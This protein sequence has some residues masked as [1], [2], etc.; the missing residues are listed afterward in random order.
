MRTLS[1]YSDYYE[2]KEF[3]LLRRIITR[4]EYE[5]EEYDLLCLFEGDPDYIIEEGETTF[6]DWYKEDETLIHTNEEEVS[7]IEDYLNSSDN[8]DGLENWD[9]FN[10]E[11]RPKIAFRNGCGYVYALAVYNPI[12]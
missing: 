11:E 8:W 7:L 5:N 2:V 9:E 12:V 1:I 10:N 4:E 3:L 6:F